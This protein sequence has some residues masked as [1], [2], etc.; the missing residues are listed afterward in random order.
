MEKL[1][2]AV[3]GKADRGKTETLNI[4]I[5]LLSCVS[6]EYEIKKYNEGT[7]DR[8]AA[9]TIGGKKICVCT[10]GDNEEEASDNVDLIKENEADIVFTAFHNTNAASRRVLKEFT[11]QTEY[12]FI[13][14]P[15][16]D[17]TQESRWLATKFFMQV[18]QLAKGDAE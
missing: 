8:R 6:Y 5:D 10:A 1:I 18:M 12:T 15:K 17:D 11:E 14:E 16:D 13:P 7:N 3:Q 4:L 9:F 2:I